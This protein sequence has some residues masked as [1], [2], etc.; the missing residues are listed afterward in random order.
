[1][2]RSAG[3]LS[4]STGWAGS[5][6]EDCSSVSLDDS[7]CKAQIK[8][9]CQNQIVNRTGD[10][11]SSS[12]DPLHT[13]AEWLGAFSYLVKIE[14]LNIIYSVYP[15]VFEIS[16]FLFFW[17]FFLF[18]FSD[19]SPG[20]IFTLPGHPQAILF[21]NQLKCTTDDKHFK[22]VVYSTPQQWNCE[23]IKI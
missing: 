6:Y 11:T 17:I 15:L 13:S 2:S 20:V 1:M 12:A 4:C 9:K 18:S 16:T 21:K 7:F 10:G 23:Q 22:P 3:W 8:K 5:T 14:V 19:H